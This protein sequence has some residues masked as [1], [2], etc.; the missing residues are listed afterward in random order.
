M[1][2][3]KTVLSHSELAHEI[4][5]WNVESTASQEN[6]KTRKIAAVP[7]L[8]IFWLDLEGDL[9]IVTNNKN[10]TPREA[11]SLGSW[12]VNPQNHSEIWGEIQK[13]N[14]KW[15]GKN[16]MSIPR[17]RI[18][19]NADPAGTQFVVY[20]PETLKDNKEVEDKIRA[21][22]NLPISNTVFDYTDTHYKIRG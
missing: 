17:G 6:K 2:K 14:K 9:S 8:G 22:F 20:L 3:P 5:V 12:K 19:L 15:I 7:I 13:K 10:P 21:D 16:Y 11:V 18:S 1:K 4:Y